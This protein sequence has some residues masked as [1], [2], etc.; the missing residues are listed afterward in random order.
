MKY[1]TKPKG[2]SVDSSVVCSPCGHLSLSHNTMVTV[3]NQSPKTPPMSPVIVSTSPTQVSEVY[4]SSSDVFLNDGDVYGCSTPKK[5]DIDTH[6]HDE[7]L[8]DDLLQGLCEEDLSIS[9][10]AS[11]QSFHGQDCAL[12]SKLDS[13]SSNEGQSISQREREVDKRMNS[14]ESA[15][16]EEMAGYPQNLTFSYLSNTF[17][18]LPMKVLQCFEEYRGISK[19]YGQFQ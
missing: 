2:A 12:N 8:Y 18:G 14:S 1:T 17:Y 6:S 4:D 7:D 11:H 9:Y 16:I 15:S 3:S 13:F 5:M 19:L 10:M